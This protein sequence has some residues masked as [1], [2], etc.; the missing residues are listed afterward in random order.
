MELLARR[1]IQELEGDEG[2]KHLAEYAD[3]KTERGQCMLKSICDKMGFDSLGFSPSSA[4]SA[5]G[6]DPESSA[7]TAGPG[8]NNPLILHPVHPH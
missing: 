1:V 2:H 3:A 6:L 5:I 4:S 7:R 8:R